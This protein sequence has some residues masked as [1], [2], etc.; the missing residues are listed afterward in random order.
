MVGRFAWATASLDI[1][2]I[3]GLI[4]HGSGPRYTALLDPAFPAK[5]ADFAGAV[6]RRYPWVEKF[7]PVNEPVT[8]ARFSGL[9]MVI[10]IPHAR[11]D[12]SLRAC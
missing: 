5:A 3:V 12:E 10:G 2:P 4:H 11:D 8:T 7:T 1:Q 9:C 6:A